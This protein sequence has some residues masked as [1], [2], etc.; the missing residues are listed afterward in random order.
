MIYW[1][2]ASGSEPV[3]NS[4]LEVLWREII[5]PKPIS[6]LG[7][8]HGSG[9][10]TRASACLTPRLAAR[11]YPHTWPVDGCYS[12]EELTLECKDP[13]S[14]FTNWERIGRRPVCT[15]PNPLVP[16]T[17]LSPPPYETSTPQST[18]PREAIL[19][20]NLRLSLPFHAWFKDYGRFSEPSRAYHPQCQRRPAPQPSKWT[21]ELGISWEFI[22]HFQGPDTDWEYLRETRVTEQ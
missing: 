1:A 5:S 13:F 21:T 7:G 16:A 20:A 19:P 18:V 15:V 12:L 9:R 4:S 6:W 3:F 2:Q 22:Y 10:R 17:P 14:E 8:Q 11:R